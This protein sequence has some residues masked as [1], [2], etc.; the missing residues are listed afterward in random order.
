MHRDSHRRYAPKIDEKINTSKL[1]RKLNFL[2]PI[3]KNRGDSIEI[4]S[5]LYCF[6]RYNKEGVE[7][8][9][10]SRN[11]IHYVVITSMYCVEDDWYYKSG[12][13]L[14]V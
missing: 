9:T 4:L 2:N 12:R 13:F 6:K 1:K 3:F 8:T 5:K 14:T 7:I 10:R 11:N